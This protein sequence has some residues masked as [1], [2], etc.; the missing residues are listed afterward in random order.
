M[1]GKVRTLFPWPGVPPK[2]RAADT[3]LFLDLIIEDLASFYRG[4]SRRNEIFICLL[5]RYHCG[6]LAFRLGNL[7][8]ILHQLLPQA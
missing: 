5:K 1:P 6:L 4:F 2:H 8:N 7:V 3:S